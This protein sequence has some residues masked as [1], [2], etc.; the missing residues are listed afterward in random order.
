MRPLTRD[1]RGRFTRRSPDYCYMDPE[2]MK[3]SLAYFRT[4]MRALDAH[5]PRHIDPPPAGT[6]FCYDSDYVTR[7][8]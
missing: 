3:V 1:A 4:A 7:Q 5:R 6:T 8:K 2:L